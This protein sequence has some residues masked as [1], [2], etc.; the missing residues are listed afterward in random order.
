MNHQFGH[1]AKTFYNQDL[2][3]LAK[4]L[5]NKLLIIKQDQEIIVNK[6]VEVEA[7]GHNDR[8]SHSY[9]NKKTKRNQSMFLSGGHIYVYLIYG[10]HHCLNIV[11]GPENQGEGILIRAIESISHN[12]TTNGPGKLTKALKITKAHDGVDLKSHEN[13]F[14]APNPNENK[15]QIIKQFNLIKQTNNYDVWQDKKTKQKIIATPRININ[16][17]GEDKHLRWRFLL[18]DNQFVSRKIK[19]D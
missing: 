9:Q 16:Y 7:Y 5:L 17:A 19:I 8:A 10:I 14:L 6:I 11:S 1:I 2:L 15:K 12:L 18:K 13:I 4:N 3:N